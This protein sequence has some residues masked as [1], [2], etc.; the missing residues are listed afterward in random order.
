MR[1]L[2]KDIV[3][4]FSNQ[5]LSG[6]SWHCRIQEK[7]PPNPPF[8]KG[9]MILWCQ[10][11][12]RDISP[13]ENGEYKIPPFENGEY[14]IPPFEKG[15]LGGIFQ[16]FILILFSLMFFL[17][18]LSPSLASAKLSP[19][20]AVK[21]TLQTDPKTL[22]IQQLS[23]IKTFE[24]DLSQSRSQA[25]SVSKG[26]VW[27]QKPGLFRWNIQTPHP[28]QWILDGR[29]LWEYD[30]DLEQIVVQPFNAKQMQTPFFWLTGEMATQMEPYTV[31][32]GGPGE[33]I[34]TLKA[35]GNTQKNNHKPKAIRLFFDP[36]RSTGS[37]GFQL[38]R[39]ELTEFTGDTVIVQFVHIKTNH[40]ISKNYFEFLPPAGIDILDKRDL[41]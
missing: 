18:I 4:T 13:F 23:H 27:I 29:Q 6:E 24:A 2:K 30:I 35:P 37:T 28:K 25:S 11:V 21:S 7:I 15:G 5:L 31:T 33:W 14:K 10:N 40:P 16:Y 19:I 39:F 9:G 3:L 20:P 36:D 1:R 41:L 38:N 34:L 17:L 8:S 12:K 26:H 22:L 32:Q